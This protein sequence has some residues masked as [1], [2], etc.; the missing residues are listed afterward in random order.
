MYSD[1][2]GNG[3]NHPG[4]NFPDKRPSDKTPDKNPREQLTVNLYS[5]LLSRS[6]VLGLLKMGGSEM[7]DVLLGVPG[8]GFSK[9]ESGELCKNKY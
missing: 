6:F 3:Q 8:W 5:G 1:R 2:R 9:R 7:C 4:L